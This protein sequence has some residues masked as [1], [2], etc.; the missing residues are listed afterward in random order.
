MKSFD[1]QVKE[2]TDALVELINNSD[3]PLTITKYVLHD[4]LNATNSALSQRIKIEVEN[5]EKEDED[6][7]N[8]A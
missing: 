8:G 2:Y 3:M 5:L 4:I 1:L 7:S 6:G